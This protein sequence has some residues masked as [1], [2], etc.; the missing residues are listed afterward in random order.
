LALAGVELFERLGLDGVERGAGDAVHN[1]RA[2]DL[3][4]PRILALGDAERVAQIEEDRQQAARRRR[5]DP[6][7]K[8]V[9]LEQF[10]EGR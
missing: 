8:A 5:V 10:N 2:G 1:H 9:A 6:A 3:A 4:R 7:G